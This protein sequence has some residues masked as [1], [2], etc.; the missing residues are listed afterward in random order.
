MIEL[1][2]PATDIAPYLNDPWWAQPKLDGVRLQLVID[3]HVTAVN[4]RGTATTCPPW[5]AQAV[6]PLRGVRLDGELVGSSYHVFDVLE[7]G[8]QSIG[9]LPYEQRYN[10]LAELLAPTPLR[11]VPTA[12]TRAQKQ[13]MLNVIRQQSGEGIVFKHPTKAHYSGRSPHWIKVKFTKTL[14]AIVLGHNA[15]RSVRLGVVDGRQ[16]QGVG[17]VTVYPNQ[18][19]PVIGQV[20]EVRYLYAF[21]DSRQLFQPVLLRVRHDV[22]PEECGVEQLIYRGA[23]A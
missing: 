6:K 9:T 3:A 11:P 2:T 23:R 12:I 16:V 7:L 21:P 19:V 1:L 20:V 14:S 10:V 18:D 13:A 5:L 4:K 17:D 15:K 22:R 8:G